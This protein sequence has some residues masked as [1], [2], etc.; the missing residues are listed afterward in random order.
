MTNATVI[1]YI[2]QHGGES[3]TCD[4]IIETNI[5]KRP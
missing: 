1:T 2:V 5:W 4:A 3:T